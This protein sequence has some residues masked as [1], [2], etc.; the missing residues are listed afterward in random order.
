[1]SPNEEWIRTLI[2]TANSEYPGVKFVLL[3]VQLPSI[4]GGLAANYAQ[5]S[6][7]ADLREIIYKV[8]TYNTFLKNIADEYDYVDYV[9]V[10]SQFDS[11]NNMPETSKNVNCRNTKTEYIGTNGVHPDN[12]GYYQISDIVYRYIMYILNKNS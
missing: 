2:E 12:S 1:M 10:A 7:L 11:E 6:L 8:H 3:G 4:N 9:D 5:T